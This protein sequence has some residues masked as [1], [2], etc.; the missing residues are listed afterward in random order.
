M[1]TVFRK[2]L[3]AI[4]IIGLSSSVTYAQSRSSSRAYTS[5]G[6][7]SSNS[8][9][10]KSNKTARVATRVNTGT[11]NHNN[12]RS[13]VQTN[14][15][16]V[17]SRT[18]VHG[19]VSNRVNNRNNRYVHKSVRVA[20]VPRSA[21]H[22]YH[23]NIRY[24]HHKGIFY[25]SSGSA[26]ISILPPVG[27]RISVL[28]VGFSR[29]AV[30]SNNYY[31]CSGAYYRDFNGGGYEVVQDPYSTVI[32]NTATTLDVLPNNYQVVESNGQV[33]FLSNGQYYQAVSQGDG[34]V[35]YEVVDAPQGTT[36][37]TL[38]SGHEV[39]EFDG[40]VYFKVEN[41]YY[42]AVSEANGNVVY[43]VVHVL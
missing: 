32:N 19:Q 6:N 36:L 9:R 29:M 20:T 4:A 33:L 5:K 23:N 40:K 31:Y 3:L 43:Q 14:N 13:S 17:Q 24:S 7:N 28:P 38:P 35:V 15:G 16:R 10:T 25:R 26:F 2:T 22:V 41:T 27:L 30:R 11:H 42:K 34:N 18:V 1:K 8:H 12:N 21:N 37:D 39:V